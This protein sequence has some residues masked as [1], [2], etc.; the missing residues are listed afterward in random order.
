[1][2]VLPRQLRFNLSQ[3]DRTES[4]NQ[5]AEKLL[6]DTDYEFFIHIHFFK[7]PSCIWLHLAQARHYTEITVNLYRKK[8]SSL[9][10]P[11][12]QQTHS[13]SSCSTSHPGLILGI[14][15]RFLLLAVCRWSCIQRRRKLPARPRNRNTN[16]CLQWR[17]VCKCSTQNDNLTE[18]NS[19]CLCHFKRDLQQHC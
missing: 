11:E 9:K 12:S 4:L 6:S 14:R 17:R 7:I 10:R 8:K 19:A 16:K 3:R 18:G 13:F 2:T 1:M 15:S 5:D